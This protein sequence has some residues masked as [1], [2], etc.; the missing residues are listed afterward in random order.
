MAER[1]SDLAVHDVRVWI[2]ARDFGQSHRFY[3]ALGW[4][5]A[6]TNGEGLAQMEL[7]GHRF[8]LQDHYERQWNEN[9][10]ITVDVADAQAWF[11]HVTDV[12]AAGGQGEARVTEPKVEDFGAT[13]IY[14]WD[15][16]GVLL[17]F[18][19]WEHT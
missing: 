5:T 4:T 1:S 3:E 7:A 14:V 10:M 11:E 18:T 15:P 2:G 6:W 19:Q 13:I 8:I 16:S 12:L 9:S 17:H